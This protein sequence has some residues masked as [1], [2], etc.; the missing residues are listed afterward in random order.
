MLV[1]TACVLLRRVK[2]QLE[3]GRCPCCSCPACY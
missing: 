3:C 2:P 1:S